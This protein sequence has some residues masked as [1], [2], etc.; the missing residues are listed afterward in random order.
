MVQEFYQRFEGK[1]FA[2]IHPSLS[3]EDK[4]SA[5][6][7]RQRLLLYP[8]GQ[9]INGVAWRWSYEERYAEKQVC[10]QLRTCS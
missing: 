6:I 4:I 2:D 8:H 10:N 7:Q 9:D 1:S 5:L 3:N